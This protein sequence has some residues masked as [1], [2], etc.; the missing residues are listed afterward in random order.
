MEAPVVGFLLLKF[1]DLAT[2]STSCNAKWSVDRALEPLM[3]TSK[4]ENWIMLQSMEPM[5]LAWAPTKQSNGKRSTVFYMCMHVHLDVAYLTRVS[6]S[7]EIVLKL[8]ELPTYSIFTSLRPG[9]GSSVLDGISLFNCLGNWDLGVKVC[10][11]HFSDHK[12]L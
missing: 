3:P 1:F 6:I 12:S 5:Q 2:L 8:A 9:T 11:A 10:V 4:G 7:D